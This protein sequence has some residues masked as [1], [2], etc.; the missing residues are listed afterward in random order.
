[1]RLFVFVVVLILAGSV[2]SVGCTSVPEQTPN[3]RSVATTNKEVSA[4]LNKR[5]DAIDNIA[6]PTPIR[7][8]IAEQTA[9]IRA[10]ASKLLDTLGQLRVAQ[11]QSSE[12]AKTNE[13]QAE[14]IRK[15]ENE[16]RDSLR[17]QISGIIFLSFLGIGAAAVMA[18]MGNA[19]LALSIAIGSGAVLVTAI[20]LQTYMQYFAIAGGLLIFGG[21]AYAARRLVI[22]RRATHELVATVEA[23][24]P[25]DLSIADQL[26]SEST[27][28]LVSAVRELPSF[29]P[30]SGQS[31]YEPTTS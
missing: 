9:G 30:S 21:L 22:E 11:T 24:R 6:K 10:D 18:V 25:A 5:A 4:S 29:A 19:R 7:V 26:Q 20:V 1:M 13:R 31:V 23:I 8:R 28:R 14:R 17:K 15:L 27:R 3:I 16:R 2:G 12:L